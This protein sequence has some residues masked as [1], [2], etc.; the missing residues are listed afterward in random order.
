MAKKVNWKKIGKGAGIAL[1]TAAGTALTA[2]IGSKLAPKVQ[3]AVER[4][5]IRN[6]EKKAFAPGGSNDP[7]RIGNP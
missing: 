6:M 4:Q 7:Y 5:K 2:Y 3:G 1:G